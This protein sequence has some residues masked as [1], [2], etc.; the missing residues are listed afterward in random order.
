MPKETGGVL[1][2]NVKLGFLILMPKP[3]KG[4]QSNLH[5]VL[6]PCSRVENWLR[7]RRVF[8]NWGFTLIEAWRIHVGHDLDTDTTQDGKEHVEEALQY[9]RG[10]ILVTCHLGSWHVA[11]KVL[12]DDDYPLHILMLPEQNPQT[13][14]FYEEIAAKRKINFIYIG[15]DITTS[16][17][18]LK[19][20]KRNELVAIQGDRVLQQRSIELP[21]FGKNASFPIGPAL[22]SILSGA[23]LIPAVTVRTPEKKYHVAC[24]GLIFPNQEAD[25][26][27]EITRL[28]K[29]IVQRLEE[30]IQTYPY[31]WFN[32]FPVWREQSD[33]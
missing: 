26:E 5:Q 11:G 18:A 17:Q 13:R 22:L 4:I 6:G 21:F 31:Q 23:P 27:E 2:R 29:E 9:N 12:E 32:F 14:K 8:R 16:L 10:G 33:P 30:L 19:A 20:L 1:G 15:E 25:R 7:A 3:R 28:T 24:F